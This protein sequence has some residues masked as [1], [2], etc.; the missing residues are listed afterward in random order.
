LIQ[1]DPDLPL[2]FDLYLRIPSW[3]GEQ[4]RVTVNGQA[5]P[6]PPAPEGLERTACGYDPRRA[7]YIALR[8]TWSPGDH[9]EIHFDMP[10]HLHR[11]HP[12]VSG[13]RGKAA[14]SRGPLVYCLESNDNP[15]VG[16]F[17][18]RLDPGTLRAE[19]SEELFGGIC[20]LRGQTGGGQSFTAIPYALWANRGE[21]QMTVWMNTI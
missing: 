21:S 6:V 13:H 1:I 9:L 3:S 8:R 12:R 2:E 14:L 20:V 19:F 4:S 11:A 7:R 16:L 5:E 18:D 15:G 10:I 17:S